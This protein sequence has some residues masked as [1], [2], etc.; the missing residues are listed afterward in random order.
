MQ[1][2][3]LP[4]SK[5]TKKLSMKNSLFA[6][7][8]IIGLLTGCSKDLN[9]TTFPAP[10]WQIDKTGKSPVSMTAIVSTYYPLNADLLPADKL[11]AFINGECRGIG[12][13]VKISPISSVFFI[14]I[15]GTAAEQ[16]KITF[17]YYSSKT[18]YMYATTDFLTFKV[19]ESFGTADKPEILDLK[20]VD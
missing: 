16:N 14:L 7:T 10:S 3:I 5:R 17:K 19:D 1:T 11:G 9:H 18:S 4:P 12:S 2:G 15:H 20:P 8:L 6:A 13:L